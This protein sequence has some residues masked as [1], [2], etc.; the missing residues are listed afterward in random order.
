MYGVNPD[1]SSGEPRFFAEKKT[2]GCPN[3]EAL[4][5]AR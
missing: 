2:G 5:C 1:F 4:V 3:P